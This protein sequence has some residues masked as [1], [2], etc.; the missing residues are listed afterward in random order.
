MGAHLSSSF[1]YTRWKNLASGCFVDED[2]TSR[3][4]RETMRKTEPHLPVQCST[5]ETDRIR[6]KWTDLR[7]IHGVSTSCVVLRTGTFP[8]PHLWCIGTSGSGVALITVP[9]ESS[10][11]LTKIPNNVWFHEF[12]CSSPSW[13]PKFYELIRISCAN[14]VIGVQ[15]SVLDNPFCFL[16]AFLCFDPP[17]R[18]N[19]VT[20]IKFSK[21]I[22]ACFCSLLGCLVLWDNIMRR[23]RKK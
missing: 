15:D 16:K 4:I 23:Q 7:M 20:C 17:G 12:L 19:T 6:S 1:H 10:C 13:E 14:T 9:S 5:F 11:S 21:C 2:A 3:G 22:R 18:I 8:H